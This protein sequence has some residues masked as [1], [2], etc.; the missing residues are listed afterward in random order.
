MEDPYNNFVFAINSVHTRE[1]YLIWLR[2]FFNDIRL[3][4]TTQVQCKA[5]VGLSED[6]KDFALLSIMGFLQTQ[7]ERV[8][9]KEITG[10]TVRS[11]YKAIKLFCDMN[12]ILIPWKKL[13][14]GLPRGR[15]WADDRA[16]TIEEIRKIVKYPDRRIKAI[17]Y[18]MV[19]SGIRLGAWDYLKWGH[20]VSS[21][22]AAKLR[23]YVG[24]EEEYFTFI[25]PEAYK[26]LEEWMDFRKMSGEN[27]TKDSWVMRQLWDTTC[28]HGGPG[29][30]ADKPKQLTSDGV[31]TLVE[32]AIKTQ[33]VRT[34]IPGKK[35]YEFPAHHGFRKF[36]KTHTEQVMKPINVEM[37]MGHS[38]GISNS[39]YRPKEQDLL[40]DYLKAVPLLTINEVNKVTQEKDAAFKALETTSKNI[41]ANIQEKDREIAGLHTDIALLKKA[42]LDMQQ[43]LKNPE[44]LAQISRAAK[45]V[46]R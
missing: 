24:E 19:S 16:P 22:S 29:G 25:T 2:K 18:T 42:M 38:I 4:G 27:V 30:S 26:E 34:K 15:K 9:N 35:R 12:D 5:F 7:R 43:L 33:S 37:L 32:N 36:F 14:R 3:T 45:Q 46:I 1:Q 20:V 40:E 6:Y 11:Y 39:Y 28:Q 21:N 8:N 31:K 41:E 13:T 23:V 44:R 10:S 17:I